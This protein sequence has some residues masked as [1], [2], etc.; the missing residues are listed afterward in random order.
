MCERLKNTFLKIDKPNAANP[1]NES[2]SHGDAQPVQRANIQVERLSLAWNDSIKFVLDNLF[3]RLTEGG[4][5]E[6]YQ[7]LPLS[8]NQKLFYSLIIC[9]VR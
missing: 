2:S 1:C 5:M 8:S 6:S 9:Q 3:K 7:Q 4:L